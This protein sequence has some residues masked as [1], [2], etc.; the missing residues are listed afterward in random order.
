MAAIFLK[1]PLG[2]LGF[3]ELRGVPV[4]ECLKSY[5]SLGIRLRCGVPTDLRVFLVVTN[6]CTF[7][8]TCVPGTSTIKCREMDFLY[9]KLRKLV[10]AYAH[11]LANISLGDSYYSLSQAVGTWLHFTSTVQVVAEHL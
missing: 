10:L 4:R 8:H 7:N 3:L 1:F 2:V 9:P 6:A 5:T 11:T